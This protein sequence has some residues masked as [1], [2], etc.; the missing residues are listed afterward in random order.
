MM[1]ISSAYTL[2][3]FRRSTLRKRLASRLARLPPSQVNPAP[4]LRRYC[5]YRDD[6]APPFDASSAR[7]SQAISCACRSKKDRRYASRTLHLNVS[8]ATFLISALR[9]TCRLHP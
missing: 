2:F 8:R 6:P 9:G 3:A 5:L 7:R 1:V 4:A